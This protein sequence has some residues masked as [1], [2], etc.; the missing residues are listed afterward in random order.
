MIQLE[1]VHVISHTQQSLRNENQ[2]KKK[3]NLRDENTKKETRQTTSH[4]CVCTH[5]REKEVNHVFLILF[6]RRLRRIAYGR[7]MCSE[8]MNE[9][10]HM[11]K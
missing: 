11:G 1:S 8:W 10:V 4:M 5:E 6:L 9:C 7:E 2:R 3:K